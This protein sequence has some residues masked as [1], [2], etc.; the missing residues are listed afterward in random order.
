[1]VV[2]PLT[3]TARFAGWRGV[4]GAEPEL[5]LIVTGPVDARAQWDDDTVV[6]ALAVG[7]AALLLLA[8][9]VGPAWPRSL[10]L[11]RKPL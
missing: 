8:G 1:V 2:G 5:T 7:L 4:D 6:P 3:G 11:C 9:P 10:D